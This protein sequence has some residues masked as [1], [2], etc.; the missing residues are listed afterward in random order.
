[1]WLVVPGVGRDWT[2]EREEDDPRPGEHVPPL[3]NSARQPARSQLDYPV[4][5]VCR[6]NILDRT[7]QRGAGNFNYRPPA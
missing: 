3:P 7:R 2:G 4:N 6:R 1:M 5:P